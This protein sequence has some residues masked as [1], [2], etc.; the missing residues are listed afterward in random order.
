LFTFDNLIFVADSHFEQWLI[1]SYN[2][3]FVVLL[4]I[5]G[6]SDFFLL[7]FLIKGREW[8]QVEPNLLYFVSSIV[9]GSDN[10]PSHCECF[11][12]F[13]RLEVIQ[14]FEGIEVGEH[15]KT[16]IDEQI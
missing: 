6:K 1:F 14:L 9:V 2:G 11:L 10:R 4:H 13:F 3:D 7:T 8:I 12:F 5:L 16:H 15:A